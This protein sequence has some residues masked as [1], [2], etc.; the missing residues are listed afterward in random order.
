MSSKTPKTFIRNSS[1]VAGLAG[2]FI[3]LWASG[4]VAAKF[5]LPYAEPFTLMASRFVVGSIILVPA[6]FLL[7]AEWPKNWTL[8]LHILVAGFGIQTLYLIGVY[9]GIWLGI[10][11]GLAALV[12]GLQ[13][14]LTGVLA[15]VVLG[16]NV[17]RKNWIGLLL[18]FFGLVLVVWDRITSPVD[19]LWGLGI[20]LFGLLGI[21]AG[22]LY[23]KRYCGQFD[24]RTGVA[25]QNVM[26][27]IVM[28]MLAYTFETMTIIW[29]NEFIFAVL[30]SAIGLSVFGICF[31]Y[32]L[33]QRGAAAR[34]TS[35]I[36]L[37]PPTT[38]IMGW[39]MF[40]EI[41]SWLAISGLM[42]SMAGV[43][44]AVRKYEA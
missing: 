11:T 3:F 12:V 25:L 20:L 24:V 19:T 4:F 34:V 30:W 13:P 40:G 8:V 5:G 26:S 42:I 31:Y 38:A 15:G 7:R 2:S 33:V 14:L 27:C 17:T 35:L 1:L 23:Q 41:L 32:W 9:Y 37:S 21:T 43:A 18:G 44:L 6:C 28:L 36:Y 16:E 10:S 22:T 39:A 29:T